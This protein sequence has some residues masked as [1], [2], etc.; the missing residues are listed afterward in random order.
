[1]TPYPSWCH[2][3]GATG[4][5]PTLRDGDERYPW[6]QEGRITEHQGS[7]HTDLPVEDR[8]RQKY[9]YNC[10]IETYQTQAQN[11]AIRMLSDWALAEDATQGAFLSG[12]RAFRN[13]RGD[14]LKAWLL[15]IV[16]NACRDS[17]RAK[18][19]RPVASLDFNPSD[20]EG[21]SGN[22]AFDPPSSDES[23]EEHAV[24]SELSSTI[25]RGLD[26]LPEE[27]RLA[28]TLVDVQG[29]SYEEAA[30][31]MDCSLGTVKSRIAR[32]RAE[33]R[34]FLRE[35]QELLPQRFRLTE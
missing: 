20:P 31:V 17:L 24:R 19:A 28:V 30:Q 3:E 11:L 13:F 1:M 9:C 8:A 22:P 32:G 35:H 33:V 34:D 25:Q 15:R 23:P 27:R 29:F 10:V 21:Q 12:Y 14:S 5:S 4:S 2:H 18:K 26:S 6:R 16:A 7:T